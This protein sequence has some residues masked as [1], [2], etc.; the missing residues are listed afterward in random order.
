M[1]PAWWTA[2][3]DGTQAGTWT[4]SDNLSLFRYFE[5]FSS[6]LQN[7]HLSDIWVIC[8]KCQFE[9]RKGCK[10]LFPQSKSQ[11]IHWKKSFHGFWKA[12]FPCTTRHLWI[13]CLF[14]CPGFSGTNIHFCR[15]IDK[16]ANTRFSGFVFD[17]DFAQ[18]I[19]VW[20]RFH[21]DIWTKN[22]P[23]KPLHTRPCSKIHFHFH[24]FARDGIIWNIL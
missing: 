13:M 17:S 21:S 20:L 6:V 14:H 7:R 5:F 11:N 24:R 12:W 1:Y 8:L 15:E 18:T 16:V 23:T 4:D 3:I 9:V 2:N 19:E 22:W 10:G